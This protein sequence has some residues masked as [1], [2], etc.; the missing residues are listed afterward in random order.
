M[1][2]VRCGLRRQLDSA[3]EVQTHDIWSGMPPEGRCLAYGQAK[4]NSKSSFVPRRAM[5]SLTASSREGSLTVRSREGNQRHGPVNLEDHGREAEEGSRPK[6][7]RAQK[8]GWRSEHE[9]RHSPRKCWAP[10][11]GHVDLQAEAWLVAAR[12]HSDAYMWANIPA[13]VEKAVEGI[14]APMAGDIAEAK[15]EQAA[16]RVWRRRPPRCTRGCPP[17]TDV[18]RP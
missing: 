6:V 2:W 17:W 16:P 1:R 10:A 13:C 7:A 18:W 3:D 8:F 5:R 14:I 11:G 4:G 12:K 9:S 15:T